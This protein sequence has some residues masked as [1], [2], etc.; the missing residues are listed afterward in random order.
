[1]AGDA[2]T[3]ADIPIACEI[4]R[5][6]GLPLERPARPHLE[7]WYRGIQAHPGSRGVLDIA[8]QA[9]RWLIAKT[10]RSELDTMAANTISHAAR[11]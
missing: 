7:R 10:P 4:H 11:E 2:F 1:M 5:W 3:M 9:I 8:H 6:H